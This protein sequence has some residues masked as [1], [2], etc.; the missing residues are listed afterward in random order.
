MENESEEIIEEKPITVDSS[1]YYKSIDTGILKNFVACKDD[2]S[3]LQELQKLVHVN[4]YEGNPR[5]EILVDLLFGICNFCVE[6][7]GL[8]EPE[9]QVDS[10]SSI[11][12]EK[13]ENVN[14]G[15]DTMS[16]ENSLNSYYKMATIVSI[17]AEV[18]E[19]SFGGTIVETRGKSNWTKDV[20]VLS[21]EESFSLF[22]ELLMAK[23]ISDPSKGYEE[24]LDIETV[25]KI[26]T[27]LSK[28]F[29]R[30]YNAY[31]YAFKYEQTVVEVERDVLVQIPLPPP[32]LSMGDLKE[33][34]SVNEVKDSEAKDENKMQEEDQELNEHE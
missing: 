18:V 19:S 23:C 4:H 27:F 13:T 15:K 31:K 32:V 7:F 33:Q 26:V 8:E 30:Y 5:S 28:T 24:V 22:K 29:F 1:N 21:S 25:N 14:E 6:T 2:C 10:E 3:R 9:S 34:L 17:L 12:E 11:V 16:E 20:K